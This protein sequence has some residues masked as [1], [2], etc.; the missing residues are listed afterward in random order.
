MTADAPAFAP[1]IRSSLVMM[2]DDE[3]LNLDMVQA[4]LEDVGFSRFLGVADPRQALALIESHRP[5]VIL[6][7]ILMPEVDGFTILRQLREHGAFCHLP[8]IVMTSSTDSET[9]YAALWLGATDFLGKPVD[10]SELALRLRNTLSVKSYRDRLESF[11]PLTGLPNRRHF[12]AHL[13]TALRDAAATGRTGALIQLNLDRFRNV[14]EALG[15]GIGDALL[16]SV[17]T[18]LELALCGAASPLQGAPVHVLASLG[19]DEF[20]VL[21]TGISS[22]HEAAGVATR[23]LQAVAEPT[24]A[25]GNELVLT[26]S[27][28]VTLFPADGMEAAQLF[29]NAA[30]ALH[31]AKDAGGN[32]TEMYS[33]ELQARSLQRLTLEA[34]LR[35][36]I[37]RD[38]LCLHFQPKVRVRDGRGTG[39]EVL[40]RW[41]HP[42]RGL[43]MPGEFIAVAES[44]GLIQLLGEWVLDAACRQAAA[45]HAGGRGVPPLSINVSGGQ[46]RD[47]A[48]PARVARVLR[49]HRVHGGA[50]CLELTESTMMEQAPRTARMLHELK[51]L[52]VRLSIDDF[53]TGY[54]SLSYLKRFPL[55]ELKID[56]SFVSGI[57]RDADD[58][59]IVSAIIGMA[60][61]LELKVVAEGV[62]EEAQLEVLRRKGCDECQGYLFGRPMPATEFGLL[63]PGEDVTRPALAP[64][65]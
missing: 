61:D 49:E 29:A 26:A 54:S 28:S 57:A 11:D 25:A 37:E 53:G 60:R 38:E 24:H 36:A 19:G 4:L 58:L 22:F 13:D 30:A 56:R 14:I 10:P 16:K 20:G 47:S 48:L 32:R 2:I 64:A 18:R 46:F 55:D 59:A 35:R 5:D 34:E 40:V 43:V 1:G 42:A 50:I 39:A 44:S 3:P 15:S 8:V 51:G 21:L 33:R 63:L 9:K 41:Q 23:L 62:E 52:G 6:L 17:A 45:W 27:A 31:R 12:C 7:D 65:L